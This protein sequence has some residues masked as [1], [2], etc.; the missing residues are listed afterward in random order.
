ML[1][2]VMDDR[3]VGGSLQDGGWLEGVAPI[4]VYQTE[5]SIVIEAALPGIKPEDINI[6]VIG[7]TLTLR[8]EVQTESESEEGR[9]YR[10][11]ERRYRAFSR[12][13][14]LPTMV[15]SD[16]ASAEFENGMLLLT[17]PK[18]EESKPKQI[19]VTAKK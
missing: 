9:R 19:T 8:G 5:D 17:I 10:L 18:A 16:K 2:R 12:S 13:L 14:T 11:R 4:D 1:D 3:W 15:D 7:D 6:S